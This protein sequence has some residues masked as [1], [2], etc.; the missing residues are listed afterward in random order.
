MGVR[1]D[2]SSFEQ[3]FKEALKSGGAGLLKVVDQLL[4]QKRVLRIGKTTITAYRRVHEI[5]GNALD[6]VTQA[7]TDENRWSVALS[8]LA[9]ELSRA[10]IMVNYQ[11]A[12][13]QIS[14]DIARLLNDVLDSV[15]TALREGK[16]ETVRDLAER[17]RT[18]IDALA[19]FVYRHGQRR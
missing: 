2:P 8:K 15:D 18:L 9:L 5:L 4:T 12:R 13:E 17:G 7:A 11:L 1:F 16:R 19:V 3:S 14:Q 10:R 6:S